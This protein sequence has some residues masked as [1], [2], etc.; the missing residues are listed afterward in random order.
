MQIIWRRILQN[1]YSRKKKKM[2]SGTGKIL[3]DIR[4][5]WKGAFALLMAVQVVLGIGWMAANIGHLPLFEETLL[6]DEVARGGSMDEYMGFLYPLLIRFSLGIEKVLHIP[7][8]VLLYILQLVSAACAIIYMLN[9]HGWIS[10]CGKVKTALVIAYLLTFPQLLQLHFAVLPYS[11]AMSAGL[12]LICDG[13]FYLRH[14]EKFRGKV[15]IRL[16]GFWLLEVVLLPDYKWMM[17]LF[18]LGVLVTGALKNKQWR[19][20]ILVSILCTVLCFGVVEKS[21]QTP[22]SMGRVQKSVGATFLARF[23]WPNFVTC[24]FFWPEEVQETF[25]IEELMNITKYAEDVGTQ[26]GYIMDE[27]YGR[28]A[29]NAI[30]LE[31]AGIAFELNTKQQIQSLGRDYI[32]YLCPQISFQQQ[33]MDNQGALLGWNY[34]RMQ[35]QAPILTKYYVKCSFAGWNV[36]CGA[37]LLLVLNMVYRKRIK[38]SGGAVIVGITVLFMAFWYTMQGAGVQ[39]YKNVMLISFLWLLPV[40]WGFDL[41]GG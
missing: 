18:M 39:D 14:T 15:L 33:A 35:E 23:V 36:M 38:L 1:H 3:K 28:K 5:I 12:I 4:Y 21:T 37:V 24:S 40:V 25:P 2:V 31:M 7:Y 19:G 32:A 13:L 9:C 30:Y 11:L 16:C 22:G 26:F 34:G 10:G 20:R 8:Y 6:L 17:G 41:I 29:A 27:K